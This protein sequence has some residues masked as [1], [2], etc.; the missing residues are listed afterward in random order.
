MGETLAGKVIWRKK[1]GSWYAAGL[2]FEGLNTEDHS[3]T[4]EFLK[5]SDGLEERPYP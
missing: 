3:M 1:T 2:Q 4:L 5:W